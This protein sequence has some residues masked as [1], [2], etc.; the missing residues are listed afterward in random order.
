MDA[1]ATWPGCLAGSDL[2]PVITMPQLAVDGAIGGT[3][4][5]GHGHVHA[6]EDCI[7]A[8]H[9]LTAPDGCGDAG[10]DRLKRYLETP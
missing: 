3:A 2:V 10:I 8:W 7:D 6:T 4:P 5:R 9:A 1:G